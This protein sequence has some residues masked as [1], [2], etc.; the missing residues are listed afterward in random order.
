VVESAQT[1]AACVSL[2]T[3]KLGILQPVFEQRL[4]QVAELEECLNTATE[5]SSQAGKK[6]NV[7]IRM[8][9]DFA[10]FYRS[11]NDPEIS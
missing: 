2:F 1:L 6:L 11:V 8:S 3:S 9:C 4:Y 7:V 5:I 10:A